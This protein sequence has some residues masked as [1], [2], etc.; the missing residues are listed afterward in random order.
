MTS[1]L[2]PSGVTSVFW[3]FPTGLST[4]L[5]R[6]LFGL[7]P[8]AT[9]LNPPHPAGP[10]FLEPAPAAEF[11]V[12]NAVGVR[13][14]ASPPAAASPGRANAAAERVGPSPLRP[15]SSRAGGPVGPVPRTPVSQRVSERD[16]PCRPRSRAGRGELF[17]TTVLF[18][19]EVPAR[20]L[21]GVMGGPQAAV[22]S[23]DSWDR[24]RFFTRVSS[25]CLSS[26]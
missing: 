11:G 13:S 9:A 22:L 21:P 25:S 10:A 3:V 2:F 5:F 4:P 1:P 15:W 6:R 8:P 12:W 7:P 19:W 17:E 14:Q 18:S 20:S 26:A 16:A 24:L 23:E